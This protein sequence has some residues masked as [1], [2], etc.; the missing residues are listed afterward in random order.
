LKTPSG[1][2]AAYIAALTGYIDGVISV[3]DTAVGYLAPTNTILDTEVGT[4]KA[5][6]FWGTDQAALLDQLE[7]LVDKEVQVEPYPT[8]NNTLNMYYLCM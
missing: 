1:S 4:L 3:Y 7:A 2:D 5:Y 6:T 8:Q